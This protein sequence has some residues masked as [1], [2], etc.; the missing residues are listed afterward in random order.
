MLS[1][2]VEEESTS[3]E[4]SLKMTEEALPF[5]TN[6]STLFLW[7]QHKNVVC[8]EDNLFPEQSLVLA[9]RFCLPWK[10]VKSCLKENQSMFS[11]NVR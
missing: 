2:V 9:F 6:F 11:A 8:L 4:D 1:H 7:P 10:Q 3:M 5:S